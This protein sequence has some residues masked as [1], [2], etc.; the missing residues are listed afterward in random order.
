MAGAGTSESLQ[1]QTALLYQR[2]YWEVDILQVPSAVPPDVKI[3]WP[4]S[5]HQDCAAGVQGLEIKPTSGSPRSFTCELSAS[6]PSI[7]Q[8]PCRVIACKLIGSWISP[9]GQ[10]TSTGVNTLGQD[11]EIKEGLSSIPLVIIPINRPCAS[12]AA[13]PLIPPMVFADTLARL[14]EHPAKQID[15]RNVD[16]VQQFPRFFAIQDWFCPF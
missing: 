14:P 9:G 8:K 15:G 5:P 6:M 10:A 16:A 12:N 2:Q 11:S 1:D 13:P 4:L 7:R 3:R